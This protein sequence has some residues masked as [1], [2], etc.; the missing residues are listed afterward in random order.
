MTRKILIVI[1]GVICIIAF[2]ALIASNPLRRS[3]ADIKRQILEI[4]PLGTS[5]SQVRTTV[6][7][8]GWLEDISGGADA[9]VI[10]GFIGSYHVFPHRINVDVMWLFRDKGHTNLTDIYVSKQR[11]GQ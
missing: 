7:Q 11:V 10:S 6:E 3:E 4:T 9:A 5:F 1:V 2:V 8:R